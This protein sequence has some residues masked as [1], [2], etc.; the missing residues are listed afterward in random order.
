MSYTWNKGGDAETVDGGGAAVPVGP[1][2]V[3]AAAAVRVVGVHGLGHGL[4]IQTGYD[5]PT[6]LA[7]CGG[8]RTRW[9]HLTCSNGVF[10]RHG[11]KFDPGERVE[12]ATRSGV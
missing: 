4:M 7:V 3:V 8:L 10:K 1:D 6:A 12:A 2:H 11:Q 5:L 9:D